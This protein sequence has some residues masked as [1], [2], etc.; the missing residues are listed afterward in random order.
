MTRQCAGE[1]LKWFGAGLQARASCLAVILA[2]LAIPLI[3]AHAMGK[4]DSLR[5][6]E[7][8]L[9]MSGDYD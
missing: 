3:N 8:C 4:A 9:V 1:A 6:V 2:C 7:V 5:E